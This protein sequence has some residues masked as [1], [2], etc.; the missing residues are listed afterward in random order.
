MAT[1]MFFAIEKLFC[2][3]RF[4]LLV[5]ILSTCANHVQFRK[6]FSL[7]ISSRVFHNHDSTSFSGSGFMLRSLIYLELNFMQVI[8]MDI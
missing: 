7:T 1:V 2:F 6:S 3:I 8:S 4:H 5:V